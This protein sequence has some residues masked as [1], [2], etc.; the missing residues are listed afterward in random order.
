MTEHIETTA[1]PLP[2]PVG[3]T[4]KREAH[5]LVVHLVINPDDITAQGDKGAGDFTREN[6]VITVATDITEEQAGVL[7]E[8][9]YGIYAVGVIVQ[10][11]DTT[12]RRCIYPVLR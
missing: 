10:N 8:L 11:G 1:S 2:E 4:P 12:I 9:I 5:K 6:N 7:Y 3:D